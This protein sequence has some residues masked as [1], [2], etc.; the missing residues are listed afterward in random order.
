MTPRSQMSGFCMPGW[1]G[2]FEQ[3]FAGTRCEYFLHSV[4]QMGRALACPPR[5]L[6]SIPNVN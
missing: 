4:A 6:G 3:P 1:D 2:L 5:V